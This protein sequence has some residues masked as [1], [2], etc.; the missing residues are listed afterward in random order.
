MPLIHAATTMG[1]IFSLGFGPISMNMHIWGLEDKTWSSQRWGGN[2]MLGEQYWPWIIVNTLFCLLTLAIISIIISL[3]QH[4]QVST[5]VLSQYEDNLKW[6]REAMCPIDTCCRFTSAHSLDSDKHGRGGYF[7]CIKRI[8]LEV[9][10]AKVSGPIVMKSWSSWRE[11]S[12]VYDGS[13]I[14][15]W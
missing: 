4:T 3:K 14:Y 10:G 13:F 6:I 7:T 12:N 11:T 2:Q 9:S 15:C 8:R 5:K 1:D